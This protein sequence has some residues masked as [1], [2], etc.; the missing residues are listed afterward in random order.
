MTLPEDHPHYDTPW[1]Y[2]MVKSGKK[3]PGLMPM[4]AQLEKKHI[5][6][7]TSKLKYN[8]K[9]SAKKKK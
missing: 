2:V 9:S 6:G 4:V 1:M 7:D 8:A 5:N 3:V